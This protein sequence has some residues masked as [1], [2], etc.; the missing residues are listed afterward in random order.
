MRLRIMVV[1]SP[2]LLSACASTYSPPG[3]GEVATLKVENENVTT[4]SLFYNA[5]NCSKRA[6]V[7]QGENGKI[8][9]PIL[10]PAGKEIAI[11]VDSYKNFRGGGWSWRAPSFE[12]CSIIMSFLPKANFTY[13]VV[14][15]SQESYC[16]ANLFY[17]VPGENGDHL[18]Y[19]PTT[20]IRKYSAPLFAGGAVCEVE[21][22][23]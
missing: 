2:L 6:D 18:S 3:S 23:R 8:N 7:P 15:K 14:V 20:R 13:K 22:N 21:K 16:S 4:L 11:E 1:I 5:T 9:D 10:I 19:E 12:R 17:I